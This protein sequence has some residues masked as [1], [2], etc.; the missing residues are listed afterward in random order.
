MNS[1]QARSGSSNRQARVK[2]RLVDLQASPAAETGS[3]DNWLLLALLASALIF[4]VAFA[5]RFL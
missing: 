2:L 5:M 1:P 3:A 4:V